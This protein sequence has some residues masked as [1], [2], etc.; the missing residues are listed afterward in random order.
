MF[1]IFEC[2]HM[3][4]CLVSK[5]DSAVESHGTT[6]EDPGRRFGLVNG[7]KQEKGNEAQQGKQENDGNLPKF[8]K[9]EMAV[10]NMVE[11]E[12]GETT[13][14]LD[15]KQEDQEVMREVQQLGAGIKP[16]PRGRI[17]SF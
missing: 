12:T 10:G 2:A 8:K 13:V 6:V 9:N 11:Q 3:K 7:A 14:D 16:M 17:Y 4:M 15:K 1:P 5:L